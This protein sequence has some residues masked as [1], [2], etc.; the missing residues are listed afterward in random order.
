MVR[1]Y[2]AVVSEI[3]L[4]ILGDT[5]KIMKLLGVSDLTHLGIYFFEIMS[6][7]VVGRQVL[8]KNETCTL[9][10]KTRYRSFIMTLIFPFNDL[11]SLPSLPSPPI[12]YRTIAAI[13]GEGFA[14]LAADT[15]QSCGGNYLINARYQPKM[16]KLYVWSQRNQFL[17]CLSIQL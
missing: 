10:C 8:Q 13:S 3:M 9:I 11:F 14:I 1:I 15:R 2:K 6:K 17:C 4:I 7:T 16:F 12:P 5:F